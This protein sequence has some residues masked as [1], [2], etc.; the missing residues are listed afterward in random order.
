[1]L[2]G[3]PRAG[4]SR[5]GGWGPGFWTFSA[6]VIESS[7]LR[8]LERRFHYYNRCEHLNGHIERWGSI[9]TDFRERRISA[10]IY[11]EQA[12][13]CRVGPCPQEVDPSRADESYLG[14][15]AERQGRGREWPREP[16]VE[17]N[18]LDSRSEARVGFSH[19]SKGDHRR[20]RLTQVPFDC[21]VGVELGEGSRPRKI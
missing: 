3:E 11:G 2:G 17:G 15:G 9:I 8:K 16:G 21:E 13:T 14:L 7:A 18:A 10:Y 1:M 5:P 20:P 12:L 6:I 4:R 19:Q